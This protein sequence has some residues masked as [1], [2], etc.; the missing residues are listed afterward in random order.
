MKNNNNK[1]NKM[2]KLEVWLDDIVIKELVGFLYQQNN[3]FWFEYSTNWLEFQNNFE[4][5]P[6]LP[7]I[8]GSIYADKGENFG[9][10]NDSSSD[11]WGRNL[12]K[13]KEIILSKKENRKL[14]N[15]YEWNYFVGICDFLRQGALRFKDTKNNEFVTNDNFLK[16]PPLNSLR[17]L[18][19]CAINLTKN[20][21][22][23]ETQKEKLLNI[24][25][26]YGSSLGGARPKSNFLNIDNSLWIAKFPSSN[27]NYDVSK[28]EY[29]VYLLAKEVNIDVTPAKLLKLNSQYHTF[30]IKRFDRINDK[31]VFYASA[32][33]MLNAKQSENMSYLDI[34]FFISCNNFKNKK[35]QLTELFKRVV[36][37]VLIQNKDDHLKNH[38]FLYING[39]LNLA[40]AFDV[41]INLDK[42]EHVLKIDEYKHNAA[43][44][45]DILKTAEYY[46]LSIDEAKNIIKNIIE[47]L[48]NWKQIALKNKLQFSEF[49][50]NILDKNIFQ[51]LNNYAK[52]FVKI[53]TISKKTK[54]HHPQ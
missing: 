3:Q 12:I 19:N 27:D 38:G 15:L 23:Q 31:R 28:W 13:C 54:P 46:D 4:I 32:L 49:E 39:Y 36:F 44:I 48:K 14:N 1:G 40:P 5:D 43:D 51:P 52:D 17:K 33:T 50:K 20:K 47:V 29:L 11:R 2:E 42:I 30:C 41:N 53:N 9:I 6:N 37:N 24:L 35:L 16:I 22:E 45:E 34:A 7:L 8:K 25:I 10:F 21:L 26:A 18:E